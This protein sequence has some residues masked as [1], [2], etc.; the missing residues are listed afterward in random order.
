MMERNKIK[1]VKSFY[2][3]IM[4]NFVCRNYFIWDEVSEIGLYLNKEINNAKHDLIIDGYMEHFTDPIIIP[5]RRNH[6]YRIRSH[7]PTG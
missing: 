3:D 4:I 1:E 2:K 6:S 5:G 7:I